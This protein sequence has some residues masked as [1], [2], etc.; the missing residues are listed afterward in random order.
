MN[1]TK[2]I[3]VK[4]TNLMKFIFKIL[5][6]NPERYQIQQKGMYDYLFKMGHFSKVRKET[7]FKREE[8]EVMDLFILK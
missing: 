6:L 2:Y 3:R 4:K 7:F 1:V 5:D 8:R